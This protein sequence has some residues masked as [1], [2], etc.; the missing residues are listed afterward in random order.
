MRLTWGDRLA[1]RCARGLQRVRPWHRLPLPLGL[2]CLIGIRAELRHQN[3]YDPAPAATGEPGDPGRPFGR[4]QPLWGVRRPTPQ[5]VLT[6]SPREVSRRLLARTGPTTEVAFLNLLVPAW[7]QFMVHDWMSHGP[8][9]PGADIRVPLAAGDAWAAR[10]PGGEMLI[11]SSKPSAAASRPGG[12][13]VFDNTETP[14]WDGS[15]LYGST[16]ERTRLL[17][18]FAG[19]RLVIGDDG[20]LPVEE[21]R[22]VDLTGVNGNWWT[23]L[24]LMHALFAQEHNA[25]AA[26]LAEGH[27]AW[28]DERLFTTARRITAAVMAKIHTVEWTPALVPHRTVGVAMRANWHG[29]LGARVSRALRGRSRADWLIG[30]PGSRFDDHG[31][32][33]SLTEEFVA[34]YRMHPLIP[35]EF[36]MVG[37]DGTPDGTLTMAELSGTAARALV[38]ARPRAGLIATF[39][40]G[41]PGAL[42]LHNYPD[43]MRALDR[44]RADARGTERTVDLAAIDIVRD[45]ERGVPRYNDFRRMLR[46][47]PAPSIAALAPTAED[48][49]VMEEL[50]GDV[51]DVDLMV[52]LYAERPPEGFGFSETAFRIF[53]LMASRRLKSDPAFTDGYTEDSLTPEGLRWI[54]EATMAGVLARH[55]PELADLAADLR[56]PFNPWDDPVNRRSGSAAPFAETAA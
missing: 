18:A 14:L 13:P 54:E 22:G 5:E 38:E 20:L 11:R 33:Y 3:L 49:A 31:V 32:P 41:H 46:L 27:P 15:Q 26:M 56:N 21:G 24:S 34:V 53:I 8:G 16:P 40:V 52:G 2:I 23:G 37:A 17:R 45:R 29:L 35:D 50:Y 30:I 4:N 43:A 36:R 1:I 28:D 9:A 25:I 47:P 12:P 39:G 44:T 55:V 51:E 19:G 6:P 7:L 10:A 48:A 42:A